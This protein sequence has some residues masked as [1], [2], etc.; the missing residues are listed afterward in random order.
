[1]PSRARRWIH[2]NALIGTVPTEL[3]RLT[4]LTELLVSDN[5]LV[6]T[7][8]SELGLLTV[9]RETYL[10]SNSLVGTIPTIFSAT[11]TILYAPAPDGSTTRLL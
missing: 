2:K 3:G 10:T 1:M 8:P 11:H 6:G 9:V 5:Q 4:A 7:I